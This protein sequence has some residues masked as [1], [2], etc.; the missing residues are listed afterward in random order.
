LRD[1]DVGNSCSVCELGQIFQHGRKSSLEMNLVKLAVL[2][3]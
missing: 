1:E 2:F 3:L